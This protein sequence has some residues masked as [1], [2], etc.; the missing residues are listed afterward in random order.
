MKDMGYACW[1]VPTSV[2]NTLRYYAT[3]RGASRGAAFPGRLYA[4][5]AWEGRPTQAGRS[6]D[7]QGTERQALARA[8]FDVMRALFRHDLGLG[9]V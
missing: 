2:G 1:L 4:M 5:T 3:R 8:S 7:G 6:G 9:T